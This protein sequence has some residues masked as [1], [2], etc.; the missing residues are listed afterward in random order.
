M[1]ATL[2][3]LTT[4]ITVGINKGGV[5]K[6]SLVG[7]M[8]GLLAKLGYSVLIVNTDPQ[9]NLGE[10]LGYTHRGE[11]DD[12]ASLMAALLGQ[13]GLQPLREVRPGLDVVAGGRAIRPLFRP[14]GPILDPAALEEA[15]LPIA[16]DY[17]FILIDTPPSVG[18]M[19]V[20]A[21]TAARW[22]LVPTRIDSSSKKGITGLAEDIREARQENPDLGMLGVVLFGVAANATR[23]DRETRQDLQRRLGGIA[24]VFERAIRHANGVA[25]DSRELGLLAHEMTDFRG[26]NWQRQMRDGNSISDATNV[27]GD[28]LEVA[29]E[30]LARIIDAQSQPEES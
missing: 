28:Y 9:D 17:D 22:L 21:L 29:K 20:Q 11:S 3:A 30:M 6:T 2:D 4:V 13:G 8:G 10:D 18:P 23:M 16:E 12:G 7:N 5:G 19:S 25:R 27:A 26:A 24:P 1:T 14:G 15:L